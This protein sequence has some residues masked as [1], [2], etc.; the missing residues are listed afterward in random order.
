MMPAH[1]TL[2]RLG[3]SVSPASSGGAVAIA[4][5]AVPVD[6]A[7]APL[8]EALWRER[9]LG[10]VPF[11]TPGHK[12]G[13]GVDP[14]LRALLGEHLFATDVWLGTAAHDRHL[15][16]AEMLAAAAWG[17]ERTFFLGNG[18][19]SGN[20][21]F[22]LATAGPGDEVI[23]GRD[24]HTSFLTALVLTGARPVYVTPRLHPELGVGLGIDPA[25][26]A[27]ALEAHPAARLVALVSP[28]YWGVA[29]DVAGVVEVAHTRGVPVYVD[30][31]WGAHFV[32]HPSLP[33]AAMACGADGAVASVHKLLAGLSPA[34]ILNA[35]GGRV[36]LDR[37]ATA[38]RMT[39]TTSP[40]VPLLASIDACRRQMA[41]DGAVLLERAI[42]LADAARRRI[43][44][45]PGLRVL[46]AAALGLPPSRHDATRL[47]IDV[48]GLGRT[49][50]E[51]ERL[52]RGR[53]G[54]APEMSDLVGIVCLVSVGD[55]AQSIDRLVSALQT[56][57][58]ERRPVASRTEGLLRS[59]IAAG[60]PG[61][62][63]MSP[64]EAHFARTTAVTL[65]GAAGKVAAELVV[66]YPPGIPALTPGEV[67]TA[68]K[69]AYLRQVARAGMHVCGAADPSLATIR[70]VA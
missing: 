50:I 21:A 4:S 34:A 46:D 57:A 59:S 40:F 19:S 54:V 60:S 48:Q 20:H 69:V 3:L 55:T 35:R 15:R 37:L 53:Y 8:V 5:T 2:P 70:A 24:L 32:F 63:A 47:V 13:A 45:V 25:D 61:P 23:V 68:E 10:T 31:A 11:T 66:P 17:A 41:R 6:H 58:R 39:Q 28:T 22:L 7:R 9:E 36:D 56:L 18:S 64:R 33:P 67:I 52:L 29:S 38:V 1:S 14:A 51:V 42:A 26:V 27:A 30:E 65:T 12:G 16:A 62:Q 44:S 43:A 49:G